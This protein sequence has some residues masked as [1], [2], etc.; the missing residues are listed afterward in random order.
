MPGL[1]LGFL[2][3]GVGMQSFCVVGESLVLGRLWRHCRV[4]QGT[5]S[6]QGREEGIGESQR[7]ALSPGT[8]LRALP[9]DPEQDKAWG[10]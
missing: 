5:H 6:G 10:L 2:R 8:L 4:N 3:V 7:G 9:F 1:C